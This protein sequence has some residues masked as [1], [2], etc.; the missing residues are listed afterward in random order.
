MSNFIS[1]TVF[2]PVVQNRTHGP[3]HELFT[4]WPPLPPGEGGFSCPGGGAVTHDAIVGR[5]SVS[6]L[7]AVVYFQDGQQTIADYPSGT[8]ASSPTYIYV[9]A[10]CIDEPVMRGG[11]GG[12]RYYHRN[13]Q[14]SITAETDGRGAVVERYAYSECG[15]VTIADASGSQISNSGI[16]NRYTYNRYTYI[17]REWDEGLSLYHGRARMYDAVS[18]RFVSRGPTGY[19][20]FCLY[21]FLHSNP[22]ADFDPS[23]N[24]TI[25]TKMGGMCARLWFSVRKLPASLSYVNM[26]IFMRSAE[27]RMSFVLRSSG[28]RIRFSPVAASRPAIS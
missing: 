20:Q 18:G 19:T 15:Q 17:G 24:L 23:G 9:Y 11:S 12:L 3:T 14:Y 26:V 28:L 5:H 4:V 21:L 10:S 13:Q 22:L 1:G 8:V 6:V 7:S 2:Q 16:S 27:A 25:Q